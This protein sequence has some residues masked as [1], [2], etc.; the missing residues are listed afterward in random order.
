MNNNKMIV[1]AG[2]LAALCLQATQADA[3]LVRL[4]VAKRET[5]A[6]G[7]S[8]GASGAYEKLTGTATSKPIPMTNTMPACSISSTRR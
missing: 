1:M 8:F 4:D 5:V 2:V 6:A 7:M 3:R